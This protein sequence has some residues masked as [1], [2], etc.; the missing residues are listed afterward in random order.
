MKN[1]KEGEEERKLE[2]KM[3]NLYIIIC[4]LVKKEL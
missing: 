1:I 3:M 2:N 4:N